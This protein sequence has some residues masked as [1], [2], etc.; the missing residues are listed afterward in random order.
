MNIA[1]INNSICSNI[2]CQANCFVTN[3][4]IHEKID[5]YTDQ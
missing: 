1:E 4:A 2:F 5:Y 3:L